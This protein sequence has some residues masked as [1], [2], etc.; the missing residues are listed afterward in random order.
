MKNL[1]DIYEDGIGAIASTPANTVGM[2]NPMLPT[3][4]EPGTEPLIPTAKPKK[5]KK[6]VKEGILDNIEDTLDK[7]DKA[8]EFAAWYINQYLTEYSKFKDDKDIFISDFINCITIEGKNT[9]IID[10]GKAVEFDAD[11][12]VIN[13]LSK[14]PKD[15]NCV[16][17]YNNGSVN[18][19]KV[20]SY[21]PDLSRLNIEVYSDNGKSYGKL[22][23]SVKTK[24]GEHIKLN[25][26]I[27]DT[28][29]I[30]AVRAE[31]LTINN[32]SMIL[33]LDFKEFRR[34]KEL[35]YNF[36]GK[37]NIIGLIANKD[38]ITWLMKFNGIIPWTCQLNI[39]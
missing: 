17:V 6:Q 31:S 16:K 2:G 33:V 5:K 18:N 21:I 1:Y 29:K 26:I 3:A 8:T 27:C 24:Q 35:Y 32:D 38:L 19:F 14:F 22:H 20:Q 25:K 30:S 7:G 28:L 11:I 12:M 15:I 13:D 37:C 9:I 34:L 23:I 36:F 10:I 4:E 39:V